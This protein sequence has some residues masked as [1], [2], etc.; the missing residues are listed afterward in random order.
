MNR[1]LSSSK[2]KTHKF[3]QFYSSKNDGIKNIEIE[4]KFAYNDEIEERIKKM[5]KFLKKKEFV[6]I[7]WD[8]I[9]NNSSNH[10]IVNKNKNA[11]LIQFPLTTN[12]IWLRQRS[13]S[14]EIKI[15]FRFRN[16][17]SLTDKSPQ[18]IDEYL[19]VV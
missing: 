6:D 5:A 7:Y 10:E 9:D 2:G 16:G 4:V 19:E 14:W 12:D 11:I 8:R 1:L 17:I 18:I 15:P 13:Q 3:V